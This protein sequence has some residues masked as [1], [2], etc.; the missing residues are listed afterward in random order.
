VSITTVHEA[1]VVQLCDIAMHYLSGDGS[2]VRALD[3]VSLALHGGELVGVFGA[4]GC[5][6]TTL[7]MI[8]GLLE[9]PT[10]GTVQFDG[11]SVADLLADEKA[12]RDFRRRNI[13]FVFQKANLI[14]FLT[15]VDNVVLAMIIDG[16]PKQEAHQRA[17]RLLGLLDVAHR[18]TNHPAQLSGGEQQRVAIAR[19]L[20]NDP[21]LL[22]ADEPTAALDSG[23]GRRTMELMQGIAHGMGTAVVVVTHDARSVDLFDRILEMDDGRVIAERRAS[24][25]T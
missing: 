18:A 9:R 1:P 16:V 14:P 12:R 17:M 25:A 4:S 2:E 15:A 19:A 8:A 11:T 6:K 5:G 20:A 21:R 23:R 13:G 22:L 3:G 7:L 10:V 24:G